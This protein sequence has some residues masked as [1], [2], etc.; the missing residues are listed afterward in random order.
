MATIDA[1]DAVYPDAR[2]VMTHRDITSVLPSVCAVKE[3]LSTP[4]TESF[5]RSALGAH[6]QTLWLESIQRLLDFRNEGREDRFF[7]VSF[8]DLQDEPIAAMEDLYG[9]MGDE[10]IRDTRDR[11]AQW[12]EENAKEAGGASGRTRPPTASIRRYCAGS[13]PSSTVDSFLRRPPEPPRPDTA[14]NGP[15][16]AFRSAKASVHRPSPGDPV[17]ADD[18]PPQ[19]LIHAWIHPL[20]P[21]TSAAG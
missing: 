3:A 11:M 20:R 13:S 16:C 7:D 10:L 19:P 2:F 17:A 5:D 14:R 15:A 1:L 18:R 12:W 6:E 9:Q 21:P 8:A 4:L